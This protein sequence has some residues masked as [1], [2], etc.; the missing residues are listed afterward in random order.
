MRSVSDRLWSS[1]CRR[2]H[3]LGLTLVGRLE[4]VVVAFTA[5]VVERLT[6]T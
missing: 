6:L 2:C 4:P 1:S 5:A 3:T